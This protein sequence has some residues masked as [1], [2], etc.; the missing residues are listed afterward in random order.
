MKK[1]LLILIFAL[2]SQHI[3]AD[4][5]SNMKVNR[6]LAENEVA[7][8]MLPVD[9]ADIKRKRNF[10]EQPPT[11]PHQIDNY[12]IDT[13]ANKCM[14]C[15]ARNKAGEAGAPMVSVTHFTDRDGQVLADIT[16][17]RYFCTQ[18]HVPQMQNKP[19]IENKFKDV[20]DLIKP[21]DKKTAQ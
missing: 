18:C 11:I 1:Y 17:R 8:Q 20:Y 2:F 9:N 4:T 15:H 16:A 10:A 19:L 6:N 7:P 13:N 14:F 5:L 3:T 21:K 12:Q